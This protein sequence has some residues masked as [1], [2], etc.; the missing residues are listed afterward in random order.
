M[1]NALEKNIQT[2]E[3]LNALLELDEKLLALE[4]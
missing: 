2:K 4:E 1:E 3:Q